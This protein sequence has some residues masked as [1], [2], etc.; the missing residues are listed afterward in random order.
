MKR[1]QTQLR[2]YDAF[3]RLPKASLSSYGPKDHLYTKGHRWEHKGFFST[4]QALAEAVP[5][6]GKARPRFDRTRIRSS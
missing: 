5:N 3:V 1:K 6:C 4:L 2:G